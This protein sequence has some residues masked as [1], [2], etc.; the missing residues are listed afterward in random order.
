MNDN[1]NGSATLES[2]DDLLGLPSDRDPVKFYVPEWDRYVWL[3]PCSGNERDRREQEQATDEEVA[4]GGR[5]VLIAR[6]LC[7][8]DG[9][10]WDI[11]PKQV[12]MLGERSGAAIQRLAVKCFDL[13]G[14]SIQSVEDLEGNLPSPQSEGSGGSSASPGESPSGS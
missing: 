6:C 9:S 13:C 3:R 2:I 10:Y 1:G 11:S 14:Y 4:V 7:N 12:M 8:E 5:A